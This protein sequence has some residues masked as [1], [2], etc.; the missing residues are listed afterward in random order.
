MR[1]MIKHSLEQPL[2]LPLSYHHIIQGI[3]YHGVVNSRGYSEFLHEKGYSDKNRQFRMFTFSDLAGD[4]RIE[5]RNIIFYNEVSFQVSSPDVY[6][7]HI[8]ANNLRNKG[9]LYGKQKF[10]NIEVYVADATV[11]KEEIMIS[12]LSPICIYETDI[13]TKKTHFFSPA[14]EGYSDKINQNFVKKYRAYY[15]TEPD[16]KIEIR[17]EKVELK[18]KCVTKFKGFIISGWKGSYLLHG[19][20]KY[21]D[22]LLQCGL[23]S[24][25]A[26]GFGM[27]EELIRLEE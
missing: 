16:G 23:G 4:Y 1:I 2:M 19:K 18:D 27:F 11:E 14:D 13:S 12:M 5:G 3:I 25:N 20:R 10:D 22:F 21:L 9:I 8:L 26:Q 24:K 15:G 6:M 17:P 7:L